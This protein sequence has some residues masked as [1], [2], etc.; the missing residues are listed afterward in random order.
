MSS[1]SC[2]WPACGPPALCWYRRSGPECAGAECDNNPRPN[3]RVV[4]S[5]RPAS[6]VSSGIDDQVHIERRQSSVGFDANLGF[7]HFSMAGVLPEAMLLRRNKPHGAAKFARKK[8]PHNATESGSLSQSRRRHTE[9]AHAPCPASRPR[10]VSELCS[11]AHG[12]AGQPEIK[13]AVD[14]LRQQPPTCSIGW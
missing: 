8:P 2:P 9:R 14:T 12:R 6:G 5:R 7:E 11:I 13:L 10:K 3:Y 4:R 1:G